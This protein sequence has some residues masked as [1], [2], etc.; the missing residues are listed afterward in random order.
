MQFGRQ[1]DSGGWP[2]GG[3]VS[4]VHRHF[5]SDSADYLRGVGDYSDKVPD[6]KIPYVRDLTASDT[7]RWTRQVLF[8]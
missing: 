7:V 4:G 2:G 6:P 3:P 5:F 1:N 8:P